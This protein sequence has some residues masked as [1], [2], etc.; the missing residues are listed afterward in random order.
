MI[1]TQSPRM[2]HDLITRYSLHFSLSRIQL[3]LMLESHMQT[4]VGRESFDHELWSLWLVYYASA[5]EGF[6]IRLGRTLARLHLTTLD[7]LVLTR[8]RGCLASVYG[9]KIKKESVV[10]PAAELSL[11]SKHHPLCPSGYGWLRGVI[12]AILNQHGI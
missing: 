7:M 4:C 5:K 8:A 1:F 6:L 9:V 12:P 10:N 3:G 2:Q 11:P